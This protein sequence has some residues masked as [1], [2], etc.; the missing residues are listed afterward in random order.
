MACALALA[1]TLSLALAGC[2]RKGP[3][4]PPPDTAVP[5][6]LPPAAHGTTFTDP[7]SPTG[8]AQPATV[9]TQTLPPAT[10]QKK[11]FILDPLIQ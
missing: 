6:P 10:A 11:T 9:Q 7:T 5:A 8:G 4:D 3:L 1:L 2:G